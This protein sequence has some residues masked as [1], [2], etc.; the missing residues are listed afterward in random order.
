MLP[1]WTKDLKMR[2][3]LAC[4]FVVTAVGAWTDSAEACCR[5]R[6]ICCIYGNRWVSGGSMTNAGT[7]ANG[8]TTFQLSSSE[9]AAIRHGRAR[10]ELAAAELAVRGTA[11]QETTVTPVNIMPGASPPV[12]T[13]SAPLPAPD[14]AELHSKIDAIKARMTAPETESAVL[15]KMLMRDVVVPALARQIDSSGHSAPSPS[16][17][18]ENSLVKM[19]ETTVGNAVKT[20]LKPLNDKLKTLEDNLTQK[21]IDSIK[22]SPELKAEIK[23]AAN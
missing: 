11:S 5:C 4:L 23:K 3:L 8:T 17:D 6:R 19:I 15:L 21:I 2:R 9:A 10:A 12:Q 20:E 14:L 1:I 7:G 16:P 22:N 18:L 13:P